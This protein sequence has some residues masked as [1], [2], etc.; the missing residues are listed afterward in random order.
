MNQQQFDALLS[1]GVKKNVSDIHL[2]VGYPPTYRINGQLYAARMDALKHQDTLDAVKLVM[3]TAEVGDL[4][5]DKGYSIANVSRFRASIF[6]QR[7]SYGMVLRVIPFE[8]PTT[9]SLKLPKVIT[10]LANAREGLI[11]VTGATGQGKSTTIAALLQQINLTDRVHIVTVEDPIEFLFQPAQALVIQR[12]VGSDTQSFKHALRSAL[13][14]DPDVIMVGELRDPETA[15]TC[16]KAAETGHL[17][18]GTLHTVDVA[19]SISRFASLYPREE[20]LLARGRLADALKAVISLRLIPRADGQGLVPACEVMVTTL[21]VQ[22]AIRDP[23]KTHDLPALIEKGHSELGTQ[24][25]DQHLV[26]LLNSKVITL[27]TARTHA[28]S[29]DMISRAEALEGRG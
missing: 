20:Q 1:L 8:I 24:T 25:F 7:G 27:D 6:K 28:T 15:E 16:L 17:V 3:G 2:E 14:Q 23:A 9:E 10:Q 18:I 19:R 29:P 22:A 4:E 12:E 5:V 13:R 11:L 26:K 21:A